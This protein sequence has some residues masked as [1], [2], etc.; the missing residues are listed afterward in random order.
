MP[1]PV[2]SDDADDEDNPG[3]GELRESFSVAGCVC[4][5]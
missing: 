1:K 5:Q 2:F 3:V 4:S